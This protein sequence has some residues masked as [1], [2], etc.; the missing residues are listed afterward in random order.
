MFKTIGITTRR[1]VFHKEIFEQI[2]K[3]LLD[4]NKKVM[5]SSHARKNLN[6]KFKNLE[7]ID[8]NKK[9]DLL[10]AYGGDGTTLRA[11]RNINHFSTKIL[12]INGG[13]LGF[14]TTIGLE[15]WQDHLN[16][17]LQ[18]KNREVYKKIMR[19]K[20]ERDGKILLDTK[21]LN[22]AVISYKDVARLIHVKTRVGK[23]NLCNYSADGLIIA[24]PTGSTA[25]NLSAGGPIL[26]PSIE[27]VILTPICSHSFTQKP[28]VLP[29]NKD[30]ILTFQNN[31]ELVNLTLDGQRSFT[32]QNQDKIT[33]SVMKKKLTFLRK[34]GDFYF[35]ILKKKLH[36]GETIR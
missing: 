23:R 21:F 20:H 19:I 36:W 15:N 33:I 27:A 10:I 11:A 16:K 31:D 30:I 3:F 2:I 1:V 7:N 4:K 25:Y 26:Y 8:Y 29:T 12:G 32:V 18:G 14:L 6:G 34:Q 24:T 28:I 35:K 13:H 17:I 22:D 5:L 9:F